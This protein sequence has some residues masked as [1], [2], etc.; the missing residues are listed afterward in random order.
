MLET[1][2]NAEFGLAAGRIAGV[3]LL[4]AGIVL[5]VAPALPQFVGELCNLILP[6]YLPHLFLLVVPIATH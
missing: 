2:H 1:G 3:L 5:A 4:L 6:V